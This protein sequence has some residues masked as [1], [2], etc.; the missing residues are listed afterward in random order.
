[1]MDRFGMEP[2]VFGIVPVMEFVSKSRVVN[3]V[4]TSILFGRSDAMEQPDKWMVL[5]LVRPVKSEMLNA[6]SAL[7]L[8]SNVVSTFD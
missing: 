2:S 8:A 6:P 4:N 5:T 1:M 7:P 3:D